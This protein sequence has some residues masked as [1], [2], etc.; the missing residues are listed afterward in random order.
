MPCEK[1]SEHKLSESG[2]SGFIDFRDKN[3][4]SVNPEN[5]HADNLIS[6]LKLIE[7]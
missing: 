4:E 1:V 6:F 2:F 7:L 5:P 3:H